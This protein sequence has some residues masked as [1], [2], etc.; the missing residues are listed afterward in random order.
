MESDNLNRVIQKI[1]TGPHLSKDLSEQE[2]FDAMSLIQSGRIADVQSGI[3]FI[4]LRMK[5]ETADE[6]VGVL[7]SMLNE[8]PQHTV[9]GEVLVT[10]ADQYA[11]YARGLPASP[12]IPAVLSAMGI[13]SVTHS[14]VVMSPKYGLTVM[15]VLNACGVEASPTLSDAAAQVETNTGWALLDQS[16][17][18]PRLAELN[19]LRDAIIKR[20]CLSTLECCLKPLT[21]SG[22]NHL[23]TGYVHKPYPPIY[24]MCA[25]VAG[26][27][28]ASFVRGVEGGVVPSVAQVSR[29]FQ[30]L[31]NRDAKPDLVVPFQDITLPEVLV[32]P[33]ALGLSHAERAVD[34]PDAVN[35]YDHKTAASIC[36]EQGMSAL[37]GQ[38]GTMRDTIRLGAAVAYAGVRCGSLDSALES[39]DAALESGKAWHQ[40][41]ERSKLR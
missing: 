27:D 28:S 41:K 37:Q 30:W 22:Q 34:W 9:T 19:S 12:F 11:G 36:A 13:A 29:Y 38:M 1:A 14:P 16:L 24:A 33:A 35:V 39:V 23:V 21:T 2:A 25:D 10:F 8:A 17:I 4:A 26:F 7:R 20:P 6:M 15:S 18:A 31:R 32:D 40:F 3:F 5:R